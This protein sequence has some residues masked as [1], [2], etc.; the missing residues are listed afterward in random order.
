MPHDEVRKLHR[1]DDHL[2]KPMERMAPSATPLFGAI[3]AAGS[4]AL[5]AANVVHDQSRGYDQA[6]AAS[7]RVRHEGI[8]GRAERI[9]A[10][11]AILD[12][13]VWRTTGDAVR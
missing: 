12:D 5:V 3:C 7:V 6:A 8:V 4:G 2:L 13:D 1:N 10:E 11:K 9:G